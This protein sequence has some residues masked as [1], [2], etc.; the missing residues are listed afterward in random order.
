MRK[1]AAAALTIGAILIGSAFAQV[2]IGTGTSN[3]GFTVGGTE[4]QAQIGHHVTVD[5]PSFVLLRIQDSSGNFASGSAATVDFTPSASDIANPS[6]TP[7]AANAS[8]STFG[9]LQGLTNASSAVDVTATIQTDASGTQTAEDSTV[10]NDIRIGSTQVNGSS[11][12]VAQ[13]P[14]TARGWQDLLKLS[15]FKLML[16]GTEVQG[17]Y[18]YTITYSAT[19]P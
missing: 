4:T 1:V 6:G 11:V 2:T 18:S 3:L 16:D 14:V 10:M 17:N 19:A 5:I 9:K 8:T 12:P 13:I 15:D 7:I